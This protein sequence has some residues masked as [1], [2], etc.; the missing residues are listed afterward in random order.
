MELAFKYLA[1]VIDMVNNTSAL[2][3]N[4]IENLLIKKEKCLFG[5]LVT[6]HQKLS[7]HMAPNEQKEKKSIINS[8]RQ[9]TY[10]QSQQNLC[11]YKYCQQHV[12]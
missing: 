7:I 6:Q 12:K 1:F 2:T 9:S 11:I 5:T 4:Q 10:V 3:H 8:H